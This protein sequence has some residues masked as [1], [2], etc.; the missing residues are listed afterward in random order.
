HT[1]VLPRF[2]CG[3]VTLSN[4]PHRVPD[5]AAPSRISQSRGAA[6]WGFGRGGSTSRPAPRTALPTRPRAPKPSRHSALERSTGP[7]SRH[8]VVGSELRPRRHALA[9]RVLPGLRDEQGYR[10]GNRGPPPARLGRHAGAGTAVLMVSGVGADA[11]A[12][13]LVH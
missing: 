9:R 12:D 11:K 8:D 3:F 6:S 5:A 7:R 2:G 10:A 1:L 4:P 13:R